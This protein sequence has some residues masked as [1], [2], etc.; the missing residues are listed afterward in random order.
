MN[1]A[2]AKVPLSLGM[3]YLARASVSSR[4]PGKILEVGYFFPSADRSR[5]DM[6]G[7]DFEPQALP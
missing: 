7:R 1:I 5:V 4:P 6:N 3:P 2:Y